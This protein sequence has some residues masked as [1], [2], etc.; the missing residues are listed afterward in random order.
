MFPIA[1][2]EVFRLKIQHYI[3]QNS[4]SQTKNQWQRMTRLFSKLPRSKR[5]L[6]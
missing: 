1:K 5:E 4:T 2:E 6:T 3:I